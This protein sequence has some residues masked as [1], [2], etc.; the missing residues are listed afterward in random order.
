MSTRCGYSR[1]DTLCPT[2]SHGTEYRLR[3]TDTKQ[4]LD[5]FADFST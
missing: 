3:A 4:V 1:V 2:S 5:T